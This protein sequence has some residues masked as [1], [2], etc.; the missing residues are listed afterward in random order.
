MWAHRFALAGVV[1]IVVLG[2][3]GGAVP[4][5]D[6]DAGTNAIVTGT[7]SCAIVGTGTTTM[8]GGVA[9]VRDLVSDCVDATSDLRVTGT[10]RNTFNEDCYLTEDPRVA[11]AMWGTHVLEDDEGGW[12]CSW[13]GIDDLWGRNAGQV[14]V[15][16]PGT[17]GYAGL[18]YVFQHVFGGAQDFGDGTDI[19]GLIYEGPPPPW[20]PI[21]PP[22]E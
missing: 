7:E 22:A 17:G 16:C 15:V 3:A 1:S 5:Q 11:C 21:A 18:T 12:S 4:A 19:H 10:F 8:A 9:R 2:V 13:A 6:A 20:G 14:L